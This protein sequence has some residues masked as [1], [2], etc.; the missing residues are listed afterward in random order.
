MLS[1]NTKQTPVK[2]LNS[3]LSVGV[4]ARKDID[5][6]TTKREERSVT[7]CAQTGSLYKGVVEV[8]QY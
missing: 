3:T 7:N 4:R 8:G 6:A 2:Q 1:R 5:P